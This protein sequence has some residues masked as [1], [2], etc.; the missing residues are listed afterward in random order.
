MPCSFVNIF[1]FTCEIN[2][3]DFIGLR[4]LYY[5][6]VTIH[7]VRN[8]SLFFFNWSH[9]DV[10]SIKHSKSKFSQNATNLLSIINVATCF[11]L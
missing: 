6:V 9:P 3:I 2:A 10:F 4:I 5:T 11:D 7:E 8:I 1:H